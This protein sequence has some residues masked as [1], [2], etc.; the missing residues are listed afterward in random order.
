MPTRRNILATL[1]IS[2]FLWSEAFAGAPKDTLIMV[3]RVDDITSLDP[4]EAYDYSGVEIIGNLYENL[5][6]LA[7]R[8][9]ISP[10]GLTW[11]FTITKN[12]KFA[13]GNPV[14][15]EDA[16]F[17]LQRAVILNKAPSFII[18]QLGFTESD[19]MNRIRAT[20]P[21]RLEIETPERQSPNF[22]LGCLATAVAGIVDKSTV[23]AHR[24]RSWSRLAPIP[25]CWLRPLRTQRRSAQ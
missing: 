13:S 16:A 25:Q 12:R 24:K 22:L 20:A 9:K 5:P 14:T 7:D 10:D 1:A 19:V 6:A 21:D 17:S 23:M 18:K 11:T 3:K 2:P 4:Q 8:W 15:A